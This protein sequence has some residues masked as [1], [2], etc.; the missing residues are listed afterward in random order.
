[1]PPGAYFARQTDARTIAGTILLLWIEQ[2]GR[3]A[4]KR[5]RGNVLEKTLRDFAVGGWHRDLN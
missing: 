4:R 5:T 1:M 3:V 2:P